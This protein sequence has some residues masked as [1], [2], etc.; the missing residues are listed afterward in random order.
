M[1]SSLSTALLTD[2]YELTMVDATLRSEVANRHSIFE[3]FGRKLP[4]TRRFGVV[5]GTGRILEALLR[6]EFT[7]DQIDWLASQDVLSDESLEYL[8][9]YRFTGDIHGYAEGECYFPG[10]PLLTV[11][12]TFAECTLLE[13]LFLSILNFDSAIASAASRMTIAAHG[14]PC[15]DMGARRAH[16]RC[17]IGCPGL[18]YRRLRVH[19][20]SGSGHK[21]RPGNGWYVCSFLHVGT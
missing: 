19:L 2:K 20:R 15:I 9:D 5:A 14:R 7:P 17:G 21:V 4:V 3:L 11:E 8:Q 6:F 16:E 13:T 12:G 18:L 10:S 1:S